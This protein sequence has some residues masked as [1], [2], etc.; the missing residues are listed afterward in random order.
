MGSTDAPPPPPKKPGGA[1]LGMLIFL[2]GMF[3]VLWASGARVPE[4]LPENIGNYEAV[5]TLFWVIFGVTGF[6]F[7]LTEGLLIYYCVKYRA[8]EGGKS[9]HSHGNHALELTW[10]FIPGLILLGLVVM[11][12]RGR[13]RPEPAAAPEGA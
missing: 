2:G 1:V 7:L 8:K 13:A 6:F 11:L 12:Q 5:D 10:T 3:L 4:V 9:V